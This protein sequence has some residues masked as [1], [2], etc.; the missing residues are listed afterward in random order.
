MKVEIWSDYVCPFCYIGKR[1][2]ENA[3]NGFEDRENVEVIY[4]SFELDP[5]FKNETNKN[6][7]T[8]LA[9]KYGMSYEQAKGMNDQMT[10]RAAEV[11]LTY[12]FEN[13]KPTN[14]FDAH[15][16]S[17]FAK[18]KGLLKEVTE[19]ILKGYFT[20]ALD[21][22]EH[23]TLAKLAA[24]AGLDQEETLAVLREGKFADDVRADEAEASQLKITGV[25]FFVF[26]Q[27]Y[28]VSGAQPEAVFT[29]V[30]EKVQ[31]E[32]QQNSSIQVISSSEKKE[33]KDDQCSDGSCSI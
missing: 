20:E 11:G 24:E 9:E 27:K 32:E 5:S 29:E 6:M 28:G 17:H 14:T 12:D 33:N 7:H 15:R 3:L 1:R 25:P 23:E 10:Q 19:R 4:R 8:V 13:M 16:V 21:I 30:L 18:Q 31:E 2:F 26:N 22:S